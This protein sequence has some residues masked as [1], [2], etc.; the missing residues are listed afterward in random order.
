MKATSVKEIKGYEASTGVIFER[1]RDAVKVNLAD[2]RADALA[3][4]LIKYYVIGD[5]AQL[6]IDECIR[7]LAVHGDEVIEALTEE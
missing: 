4:L 2:A 7:F 6:S 1:K 5:A 3:A